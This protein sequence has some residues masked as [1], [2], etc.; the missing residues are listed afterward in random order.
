M[1]KSNC[2]KDDNVVIEEVVKEDFSVGS[3]ENKDYISIHFSDVMLPI[4]EG[5]HIDKFGYKKNLQAGDTIKYT[6]SNC[7]AGRKGDLEITEIMSVH[8]EKEYP[9]VLANNTKLAATREN[10]DSFNVSAKKIIQSMTFICRYV[11]IIC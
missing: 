6:E 5:R 1:D 9:L 10:G 4:F 8:P 11:S 2:K 3:E 7:V